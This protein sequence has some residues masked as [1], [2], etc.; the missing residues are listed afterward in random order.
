MLL[1]VLVLLKIVKTNLLGCFQK[2]LDLLL[3]FFDVPYNCDMVLTSNT[4]FS[5]TYWAFD[6]IEQFPTI[7]NRPMWLK[8]YWLFEH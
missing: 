7:S 4:T 2:S 8:L 1:N 6:Y 3:K 5:F